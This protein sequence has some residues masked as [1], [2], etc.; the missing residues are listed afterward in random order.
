MAN[1]PA[2]RNAKRGK[3]SVDFD[4]WARK[5]YWSPLEA[6]VLT[7]SKDPDDY[8]SLQ[9]EEFSQ[10]MEFP[11]FHHRF[12]DIEREQRS[13]NKPHGLSPTE[14][15]EW[16][17]SI[18]LALPPELKT[19]IERVGAAQHEWK[20]KYEAAHETIEQL[21]RQRDQDQQTIAQLKSYETE[22]RRR[23]LQKLVIGIAI[24]KYG[25]NLNKRTNAAR[26]IAD[27]LRSLQDKNANDGPPL[28]NI[29]LDEDT[30]RKHLTKGGDELLGD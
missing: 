29:S 19:A 25:Y 2:K 23:S 10:L 7:F 26:L 8:R 6:A 14:L 21:Q 16:V 15:L 5:A 11:N 1:G 20:A 27:D 9:P 22:D 17:V 24:L 18:G 28:S 4:L 30:I 3:H 12:D 13:R